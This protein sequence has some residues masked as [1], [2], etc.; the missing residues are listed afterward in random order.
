MFLL[1]P[2]LF[3]AAEATRRCRRAEVC[4]A[5]T[6]ANS[7]AARRSESRTESST[8]WTR[9]A[10]TATRTCWPRAAASSPKATWARGPWTEST[11]GARWAIFAC[12]RFAHRQVST[13]KRLGVEALDHRVGSRPFGEFHEG[14]TARS[15][16]LAI[17]RHDDV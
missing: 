15:A 6:A 16:S 2:A 7:R 5:I 11:R 4:A 10:E 8:A 13:L 9:L 14:E 12:A 3:C 1:L 17:N